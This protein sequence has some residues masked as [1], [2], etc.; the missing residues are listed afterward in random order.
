MGYTVADV[1]GAQ[2]TGISSLCIHQNE[3]SYVQSLDT[4]AYVEA[5]L[6]VMPSRRLQ[7]LTMSTIGGIA[8]ARHQ[9]L[10]WSLRLGLTGA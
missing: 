4:K 7:K 10:G 8:N 3:V 6:R 5:T 2:M 9:S 1:V